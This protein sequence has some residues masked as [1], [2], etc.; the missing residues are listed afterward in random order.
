MGSL[1]A[2]RSDR[3]RLVGPVRYRGAVVGLC[4]VVAVAA[5]SHLA[6]TK[7]DDVSAAQVREPMALAGPVESAG[8]LAQPRRKRRRHRPDSVYDGIPWNGAA[9][10]LLLSAAIGAAGAKIYVGITGPDD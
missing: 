4:A 10:A 8:A 2:R 6:V 7:A 9:L 1:R 5:W 3:W